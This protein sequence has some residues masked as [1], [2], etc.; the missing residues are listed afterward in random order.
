MRRFRHIAWREKVL[1]FFW[2]IFLGAIVAATPLPA[3][4]EVTRAAIIGNSVAN[5]QDPEF[6]GLDAAIE[7]F[8]RQNHAAALAKLNSLVDNQPQLPPAKVLLAQMYFG[9]GD[10]AAGRQTLESAAAAH[11]AAPE[12]LVIFGELDLREGRATS[13][14]ALFE[15]A[16]NLTNEA[17]WKNDF[18][19]QQ[20][21]VNAHAGLTSATAAQGNWKRS[22]SAAETWIKLDA[23][24]SRAH[25]K[26][27]EA[28]F[29]QGDTAGA[30]AAFQ[31]S[32]EL[33][34]GGLPAEIAMALLYEQQAAA[35]DVAKRTNA[36]RA[37]EKAI[38]VSPD[39][40]QVRLLAGAW[41]LEAGRLPFADQQ[42]AAALKMQPDFGEAVYLAGVIDRSLGRPQ[43]AV[44][45]FRSL[46]ATQ[47]ANMLA[48]R[49]LSLALLE[50]QGGKSLALEYA[51]LYHAAERTRESSVV[52]AWALLNNQA[53]SE[54]KQLMNNIPEG[55]LTAEGSGL[56]GRILLA[57]KSKEEAVE[58]LR[59]AASAGRY[60]PGQEQVKKL[61]EELK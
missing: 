9:I 24:S 1:R 22:Q 33:T 2:A 43:Q 46:A 16:I 17:K 5:W 47:P 3:W 8:Q 37:M 20:L 48:I 45:R 35:G 21:L 18:R 39:D 60:F 25:A 30:Y 11:P 15:K 49:Q 59:S 55:D 31:K 4:A 14:V 44:N 57:L 26:L 7:Q 41:G 52:L 53:E 29:G 6:A 50:L 42:V 10:V 56:A 13:S 61:F 36:Q 38:E 12:P 54:A 28:L 40:L 19:R 51:R 58:L 32:S 27:G 34:S 23:K